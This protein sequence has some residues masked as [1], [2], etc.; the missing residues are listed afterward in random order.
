MTRNRNLGS[1]LAALGKGLESFEGRPPAG[2]LLWDISHTLDLDNLIQHV[3]AER[4]KLVSDVL[5][6][7]ARTVPGVRSSLKTQI[8][9]NDFNLHNILVDPAE[10]LEIAGI[11]DFGDMVFAPRVNDLAVA[12]AYHVSDDD[13]QGLMGAM[14][15]GYCA[16][17]ALEEAE[18]ALLPVLIKG[19]AGP[20]DH[21]SGIPGCEPTGEPR[22]HH[23]QSWWRAARS[24]APLR[25][26]RVGI[27]PVRPVQ[28][29]E[30]KTMAM[31]NAFTA[32]DFARL[33]TE[34]QGAHCAPRACVGS[35]LSSIL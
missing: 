35:G 30:V 14:L 24:T 28:L 8:I 20:Y 2:K 17:T 25:N 5:A 1:V 16:E 13:W 15:G 10:P 34:D 27:L 9:H 6:E 26:V 29:Q 33:D 12:L 3:G 22:L 7:F 19:A 32:E 4:R 23:A 31:V 21:H 18:I 11:I